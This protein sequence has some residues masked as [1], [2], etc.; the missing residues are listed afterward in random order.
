MNGRYITIQFLSVMDYW[1]VCM[2]VYD[3]TAEIKGS[4]EMTI[5]LAGNP[6]VG[7]STVFNGLTGLNQHTGNWPGKTV[8]TARGSFSAGGQ[9][10][11]LVDLPGTY[12]LSAHSAEEKIS[13]DFICFGE[14]DGV[15]LVCDATCLE[16]NLILALKTMEITD[17]V[18]ICVNLMDEA[19]RKDIEIDLPEL[20]RILGVPVVGISARNKRDLKRL[21]CT[22]AGLDESSLA[23]RFSIKYPEPI[24]KAVSI[25][26]PVIEKRIGDCRWAA[27]RIL[28]EDGELLTLISEHM[29][30][31]V[32]NDLDL[33]A[34]KKEAWSIIR[35][36]YPLTENLC[37]A[38]SSATVVAAEGIAAAVVKAVNRDHMKRDRK[39]DRILTSRKTGLPI[40]L[41]L[42]ALLFWIT[43]SVSN[44]PSQFLQNVLFYVQ[45][46]LTDFFVYIGAPEWL[47]GALVLG[48]YR[49]SAWVISVMLPPMAIFFPLFTLLEDSGYLARVAFNLDK[50]FNKAKACGKQALTMWAGN[51]CRK[52]KAED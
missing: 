47:H 46:R 12:S 38:I 10:C 37:D 42:L 31:D 24:E 48:I 40:M 7:K 1:G 35:D 6:N 44:Y 33:Q 16:R 26:S 32:V 21:A 30:W 39:I 9:T 5:A 25:L 19:G 50:Y 29:G 51:L 49:T 41:A 36:S 8:E 3:F 43:L 17:K 45:D 52:E 15:I 28:E 2:A 23:N 20:E 14:H 22:A 34:A 13:R 11:T 18:L 4:K 27:L